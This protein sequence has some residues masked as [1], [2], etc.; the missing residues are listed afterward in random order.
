MRPFGFRCALV[1]LAACVLAWT[2]ARPAHGEGFG[3]DTP[4]GTGKQVVTVTSLADSGPGTLRA[5]LAG[6]GHRTI[7]FAVGGVIR[8]NMELY[9]TGPFVTIDGSTAPEPVTLDGHGLIIRGNRGAHDVIVRGIRVRNAKNDGIQ[10]TNAAHN[11]LIEHV[12]IHGSADG[13]IDITE[14][15]RNVTVRWSILAKPRFHGKNML[16]SYAGMARISLHHNLFI[17]A[18]Q[19]N[20]LIK[21]TRG[22][23]TDTT[24]DMR[25]NVVW[26]WAAGVGTDIRDGVGVNVVGNYYGGAGEMRNAIVVAWE[27]A[28]TPPRAYVAGNVRADGRPFHAVRANGNASEPLPAP[29]MSPGRPCEEA[30]AVARKAGVRPLDAVDELVLAE[31][32]LPACDGTPP[33]DEPREDPKDEAAAVDRTSQKQ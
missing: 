7:V 1:T 18:R 4:G 28:D 13:N 29:E 12:S 22:V 9:V 26:S 23:A 6:G 31:L 19:R 32:K 2:L 25:Y 16:I 17:G 33:S 14:G 10:I 8:T 3:A 20:P 11:V 24:V 5:A 21:M 15:S 30:H 27:P